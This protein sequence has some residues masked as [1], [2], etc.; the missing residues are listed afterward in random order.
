MYLCTPYVYLYILLSCMSLCF[1]SLSLLYRTFPLLC[2][3][4]S[5]LLYSV[6][7][8]LQYFYLFLSL[9]LYSVSLYHCST[10]I[11]TCPFC[12]I[13]CPYLYSLGLFSKPVP[14]STVPMSLYSSPFRNIVHIP[15]PPQPCLYLSPHQTLPAPKLG[16]IFSISA[17]GHR[18]LSRYARG[19]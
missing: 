17:K 4:L 13:V 10:F 11:H 15:I 5:L 18:L 2:L 16:R 1:Y 12:Y 7:I 19:Q 9:L 8:P 14:T 3:Y 6:S